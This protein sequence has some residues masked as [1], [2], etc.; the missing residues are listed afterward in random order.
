MMFVYRITHEHRPLGA[1]GAYDI[2]DLTLESPEPILS[3]DGVWRLWESH[4]E[5]I[6]A[7]TFNPTTEYGLLLRVNGQKTEGCCADGGPGCFRGFP[8]PTKLPICGTTDSEGD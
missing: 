5:S 2:S 6:G 1:E 8:A 4:L 7:Y 3:W